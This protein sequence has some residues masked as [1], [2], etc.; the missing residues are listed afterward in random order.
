MTAG[1][2]RRYG[3]SAVTALP[4][5]GFMI[6]TAASPSVYAVIARNLQVRWTDLRSVQIYRVTTSMFVQSRPGILPSIVALFTLVVLCEHRVGPWL[7]ALVF[8]LGDWLTTV[9][10]FVSLRVLAPL[11]STT[12]RHAL[13]MAS[14]GSSAACYACGGAFVA[15]LSPGGWRRVGAV[16][17]AADLA[18][19][20][21]VSHMLS[22]IQHPISALL[23][24]A[25]ASAAM[26]D[27]GRG[28]IERGSAVTRRK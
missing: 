13:T 11:G 8:A 15:S 5:F 25:I 10:T 14:S 3:A 2:L 16:L 6:T 20:A 27:R 23:G 17:L 26:R 22:D 19:Q 4:V 1:W 9:G 24:I 21:A 28:E 12:A 18:V 7:T